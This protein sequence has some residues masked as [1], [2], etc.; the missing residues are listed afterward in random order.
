VAHLKGVCC[1][2]PVNY[3]SES[4]FRKEGRISYKNS[5]KLHTGFC[6]ILSLISQCIHY[7][8]KHL[9]GCAASVLLSKRWRTKCKHF[10]EDEVF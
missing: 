4:G 10:T 7:G 8:D 3:N 6:F 9:L 5:I 2:I 1:L